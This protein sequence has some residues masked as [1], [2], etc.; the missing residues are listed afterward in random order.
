[1]KVYNEK[2]TKE[3]QEYDLEKGYLIDDTLTTHHDAIKGVKEEGHYEIVKEYDNGGKD[4]EWIVDKEGVEPVEAYDEVENIQ[5]YIPY[6]KKEL[7]EIEEQEQ[8]EHLK[9]ELELN[10]QLIAN[11][12]YKAIKYAEG[13]YTD[14]EYEPIKQEREEIRK[15]IRKLEEDLN[16]LE[17]NNND[18][19]N[20]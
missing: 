13:W 7:K 5:V 6:T 14:E 1:M 12:D 4:V 19:I 9:S 8:L 17:N 15:V 16:K 2:K 10:K 20:K 18:L 11:S 3:L